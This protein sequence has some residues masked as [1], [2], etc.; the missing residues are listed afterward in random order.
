[1]ALEALAQENRVSTDATGVV[2]EHVDSAR[3]PEKRVDQLAYCRFVREIGDECRQ[4]LSTSV[5]LARA[6]VDPIRGRCDGQAEADRV[7]PSRDRK[8]D[9]LRAPSARHDSCLSSHFY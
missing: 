5:Q 6:L 7:K 9:A 3:L 4:S 8:A 2:D 1:V